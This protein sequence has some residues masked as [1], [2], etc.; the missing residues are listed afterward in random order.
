MYFSEENI[1]IV[2]NFK[3]LVLEKSELKNR[4]VE[5]KYFLEK[6]SHAQIVKRLDIIFNS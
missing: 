6:H 2:N 1:I 3:N 5:Q 4:I